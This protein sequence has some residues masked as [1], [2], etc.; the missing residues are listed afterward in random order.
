MTS[1]TAARVSMRARATTLIEAV[2]DDV[3]QFFVDIDRGGTF[4]EDRWTREGGGGGLSR[5]MS[6]GRTFEKLGVNRSVVFGALPASASA[7]LGARLDATASHDFFATGLSIVAHPHS[8]R[9]PTVHLNVRYFEIVRDDG[10]VVDA[11]F[12]GGTDLT[13]MYPDPEHARHF[14]RTLRDI[15]DCHDA[16][17]YPRFKHECDRYFRNLHRGGEARGVGGVLFDHL[18]AESTDCALTGDQLL[19]FCGDLA[20]SLRVA[21]GPM[22]EDSRNLPF[23][24]AERRL[25]LERRGRY[26]EFN[27]LH[28]RGTAFGLQTGARIESVLMSLPPRAAWEYAMDAR[29]FPLR[30]ALIAMLAPQ[31]WA[32]PV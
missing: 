27:L 18:R 14:H 29:S 4:A 22:V 19:G 9:I 2:H 21:Y 7:T 16:T 12:G 10:E 1:E 32:A 30:D 31:D 23:G 13:P 25:Q 8:P 3:T 20:R 24:D 26:V 5:V 15:V 28:D 11:W 6:D 17:L